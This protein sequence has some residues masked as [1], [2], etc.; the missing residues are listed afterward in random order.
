M[1]AYFVVQVR[2]KLE[3]DENNNKYV[4]DAQR[5]AIQIKMEGITQ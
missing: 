2:C 5:L 4:D 1:Q 3:P